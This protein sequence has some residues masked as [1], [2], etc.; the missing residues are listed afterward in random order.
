MKPGVRIAPTPAASL[1]STIAS[2]GSANRR[3]LSPMPVAATRPWSKR[4]HA[5]ST[6]RPAST[7]RTEWMQVLTASSRGSRQTGW[8]RMPRLDHSG[9]SAPTLAR[10]ESH[11]RR[12]LPEG[13]GDQATSAAAAMRGNAIW[14]MSSRVRIVSAHIGASTPRMSASVTPS[15]TEAG[16]HEYARCT[17]VGPFAHVRPSGLS[18]SYFM[19]R[20]TA[21][22]GERISP[23]QLRT[24]ARAFSS[25]PSV[26]VV[27]P[28]YC[29]TVLGSMF[30]AAPASCHVIGIFP[31]SA[32]ISV[33][34]SMNSA[35]SAGSVPR[36]SSPPM[37]RYG[38]GV[39]AASSPT[40]SATKS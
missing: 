31:R 26:G 1:P 23:E 39:I 24:K 17:L 21:S 25:M 3:Q 5:S 29:P 10:K 2:C 13:P 36:A 18:A 32:T 28:Q 37:C 20:Y 22:A 16:S 34:R 19:S 7:S 11:V 4:T 6:L 15:I 8:N 30:A 14:S 9:P 33:A 38:P 40:T 27:N 35:K 12:S